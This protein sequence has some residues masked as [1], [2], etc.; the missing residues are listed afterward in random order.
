MH[1]RP[2]ATKAQISEAPLMLQHETGHPAFRSRG[3]D[4]GGPGLLG[5][6]GGEGRAAFP[7][8]ADR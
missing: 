7:A 2:K 5:G 3:G 4:F 6:G 1:T 8:D